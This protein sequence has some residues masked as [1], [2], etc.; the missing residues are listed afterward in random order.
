MSAAQGRAGPPPLGV[1][2]PLRLPPIHRHRLANGLEVLLV[3]RH[4]LP[5][6][7]LRLVVRA[8]AGVDP[9]AFA[10]RAGLTA[11]LLDE[12]AG[13]RSALEIAAAVDQLGADLETAA[14]WDATTVCLHVLAPHLEA[15]LGLMADVAL[16][17]EFPAAEVERKRAER[18]AALLQEKEEPRVLAGRALLAALYGP[19][20]PYGS[21]IRG[22]EATI[23]ALDA[24]ALRAY[25]EAWVHPG[26]AFLVA[27]GDVEPDALLRLLEAAFGDWTPRAGAA[28][29]GLAAPA[30]APTAA[31]I[32]DRPG[33]AQAELR[34]GRIGAPRATPD[35]FP[36]L[37]LNTVLGGSFTSRLNQKLRQEK[38]Y[39]YGVSSRFDFRG[40]PGPFIV[41][42]SVDTD[43]VPDAVA[44]V[45]AELRHLRT[46][47][48]PADELERA[49]SY[50][51]R[52]YARYFETTADVA[53]RVTEIGLHALPDD[54]LQRY[55]ER[56]RAVSSEDVFRA[57]ERH[58]DPDSTAVVV[59]APRD[60]VAA[61]LEALGLPVR[62]APGPADGAPLAASRP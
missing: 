20:H 52:G 59:A 39:T 23:A 9:P 2:A 56:V 18:L 57:A 45:L 3:E 11:D 12:G 51:A 47:L 40:G 53:G 54:Y 60:D 44:D 32:V 1:A 35:Y 33:A 38:G 13:G 42:T 24:A 14:S 41:G 50:C 34:L 36:L 30:A 27:V 16:R 10:G 15:A 61:G 46:K 29:P 8:G 7:D 19:D 26:N 43:A 62:P 21:P 37:V 49:K 58:L 4:A 22:T 6:V 5:V 31:Y 55:V 17:P 48:V 25:Y 28:V